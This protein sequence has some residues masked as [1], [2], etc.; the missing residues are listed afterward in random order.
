MFLTFTLDIYHLRECIKDL[1]PNFVYG[2]SYTVMRSRKSKRKI[3]FLST[4]KKKTKYH[5]NNM[6]GFISIFITCKQVYFRYNLSIFNNFFCALFQCL[7]YHWLMWTI[8]R[9]DCDKG[10]EDIT[11]DKH[12]RKDKIVRFKFLRYYL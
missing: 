11:L 10:R 12:R 7:Q 6:F 2:A 9:K 5:L 3:F 1:Y 4:E 8:R